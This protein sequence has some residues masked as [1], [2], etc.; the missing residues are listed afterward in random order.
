MVDGE[1]LWIYP[2]AAG[3][4]PDFSLGLFFESVLR[5]IF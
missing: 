1:A 4:R 3:T 2:Q 5:F